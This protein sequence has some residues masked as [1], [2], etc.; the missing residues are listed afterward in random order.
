MVGCAHASENP[1]GRGKSVDTQW[2]CTTDAGRP[3]FARRDEQEGPAVLVDGRGAAAARGFCRWRVLPAP[4]ECCCCF[5]FSPRIYTQK[6]SPVA[7]LQQVDAGQAGRNVVHVH[8]HSRHGVAE[9]GEGGTAPCAR[10]GRWWGERRR[11]G[12]GRQCPPAWGRTDRGRVKLLHP[13]SGGW[14]VDEGGVGC[15]PWVECC[16][17]KVVC[18][19]RRG[20]RSGRG[21]NFCVT[22]KKEGATARSHCFICAP[23]LSLLCAH[24]LVLPMRGSLAR[25]A[26]PW[27]RRAWPAAGVASGPPAPPPP[28]PPA[29]PPTTSTA[30]TDPPPAE[31][32][33][34]DCCQSACGACVWDVYFRQL[35]AWQA[36]RDGRG[37]GG[38]GRE[39]AAA[40]TPGAAGAAAF[41]ALEARLREQKQGR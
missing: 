31:P 39:K 5:F 16:L 14:P 17:A 9:A 33:P 25:L 35:S 29:P 26:A 3:C 41:A 4:R 10:R 27:R 36:R 11:R 20:R 6:N 22:R 13:F 32:G 23:R 40:T 24:Q 38:E 2:G 28:P 30:A 15:A 34:E 1:V 12:R 8:V 37:G 19:E 21:Q 7:A 18:P